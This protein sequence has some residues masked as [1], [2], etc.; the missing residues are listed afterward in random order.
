MQIIFYDIKFLA[1]TE[2]FYLGELLRCVPPPSSSSSICCDRAGQL[3]SY[4]SC[5]YSPSIH[6]HLA[7]TFYWSRDE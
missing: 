7:D 6:F 1:K 4:F 2:I 3:H 5:Q